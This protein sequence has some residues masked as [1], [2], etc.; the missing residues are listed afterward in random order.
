[1]TYMIKEI[2]AKNS[3]L[4][5]KRKNMIFFE[6]D[7]EGKRLLNNE[8]SKLYEKKV[9]LSEHELIDIVIN[10]TII[11]DKMS[12]IKNCGWKTSELKAQLESGI[13]SYYEKKGNNFLTATKISEQF[14]I[15]NQRVNN[16]LSELEWI[17]QAIKGWS[18]T[19][20][21]RIKGGFQK[22]H[23][24]GGTYVLWPEAVLNDNI[25]LKAI[26]PPEYLQKDK[27]TEEP[28]KN[29]TISKSENKYPDTLLKAKDGH[30]VRSRAELI[31]DNL[32][33]DYGLTHAY[34]RELT[35]KETVYSDFYIPARNGKDNLGKAVYIEFWGIS[36]NEK[37]LERKKMK[38]DI[39]KKYKF[40]LIEL[41]D[42]HLDN[43]DSYLRKTLLKYNI[44]VE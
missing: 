6:K 35:V 17:E 14:G 11:I 3:D 10:S 4:I 29:I 2:L 33:Y 30:L 18:I 25:F 23:P 34:E 22:E 32:L 38:Q 36:D 28:I 41:D 44:N 21:G 5:D 13:S 16:I 20:L 39:Y 7:H 31:I 26:K 43:L 9:A 24:S 42:S 19:D 27:I 8:I 37:Y 1:M 40:N 12:M 15:S